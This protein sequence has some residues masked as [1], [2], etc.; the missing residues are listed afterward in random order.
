M[1]SCNLIFISATI[2]SC[3]DEC[4]HN[5]RCTYLYSGI[6][7]DVNI[8]FNRIESGGQLTRDLQWVGNLLVTMF[9]AL[10]LLVSMSKV[11]CRKFAIPTCCHVFCEKLKPFARVQCVY[12]R[13]SRHQLI[14]RMGLYI[15][16]WFFN[17]CE[18]E[19]KFNIELCSSYDL[20][21]WS[22]FFFFYGT[23]SEIGQGLLVPLVGLAFSDLL[24]S[25]SWIVSP[26]YGGTVHLGLEPMT[27]MLLSRTSWRLYYG[28]NQPRSSISWKITNPFVLIIPIVWL[29]MIEFKFNWA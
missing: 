26:M 13:I 24:I 17:D 29:V 22:I 23:T 8:P 1:F 2:W 12:D 14:P 27:G 19:D 4:V 10:V 11:P 25:H 7:P 5:L 18:V 20:F 3:L 16:F 15:C 6:L 9:L 28:T 21:R